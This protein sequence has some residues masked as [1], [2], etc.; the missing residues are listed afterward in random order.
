MRA[1]NN[2]LSLYSQVLK[3]SALSEFI[4]ASYFFFSLPLE[5]TK[6]HFCEEYGNCRVGSPGRHLL[7]LNPVT[8]P[9]LLPEL[10]PVIP[11]SSL[12]PLPEK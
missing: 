8:R 1:C 11:V 12:L 10:S 3:L 2:D 7:P 6:D 9:V 4:Y 5:N